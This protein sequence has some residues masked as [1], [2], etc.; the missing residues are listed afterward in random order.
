MEM[1]ECVTIDGT[2][3]GIS[4]DKMRFRPT[5]YAIV[6]HD[7][8]MLLSKFAPT[9]KYQLPG[10]GL[11]IGETCIDALERETFE[12]CGIK[13]KVEKLLFYEDINF[14]YQP[15]DSAWQVLA[16]CFLAT[17]QNFDIDSSRKGEDEG[18]AEWV[19]LE[20]LSKN[21]LQVMGAQVMEYLGFMHKAE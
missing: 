9:G 3:V 20:K 7:G 2:K 18:D 21:N 19:P 1:I 5:A 13:I 15:T 10:G 6:I 11:E 4:K 17:P 16:L 12:E 14:Y 8:K